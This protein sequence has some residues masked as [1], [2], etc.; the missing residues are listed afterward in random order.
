MDDYDLEVCFVVVLPVVL[1]YVESRGPV[2]EAVRVDVEKGESKSV[3][4]VS[5]FLNVSLTSWRRVG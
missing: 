2:K 4:L 1:T 3:W 5:Y